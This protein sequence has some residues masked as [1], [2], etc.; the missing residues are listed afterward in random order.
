MYW[1]LG[2]FAC[3][4]LVVAGTCST[5]HRPLPHRLSHR[6]GIEPSEVGSLA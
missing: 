3:M 2:T 4:L 5:V 6:F 1:M